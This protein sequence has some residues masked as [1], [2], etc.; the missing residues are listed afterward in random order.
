MG[1]GIV[2]APRVVKLELVIGRHLKDA[3]NDSVWASFI[4]SDFVI[5]DTR[6]ESDM[7]AAG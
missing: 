6:R 5:Y 2:A 7:S 4:S 1:D 3:G